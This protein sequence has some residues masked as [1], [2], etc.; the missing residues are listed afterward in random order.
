MNRIQTPAEPPDSGAEFRRL[1]T[2]TERHS[3]KIDALKQELQELKKIIRQ[4]VREQP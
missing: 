1:T 4:G 3:I 2:I